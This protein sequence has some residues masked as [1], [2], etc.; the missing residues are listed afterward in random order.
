MVLLYLTCWTSSTVLPLLIKICS[1]SSTSSNSTSKMIWIIVSSL[2]FGN[3]FSI[4]THNTARPWRQC[5]Q[6]SGDFVLYAKTRLEKIWKLFEIDLTV[7]LEYARS[8]KIV[9]RIDDLG[10]LWFFSRKHSFPNK[11][12]NTWPQL[13]SIITY[14]T[15]AAA[16][17][18]I[19]FATVR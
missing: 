7:Q 15:P 4:K 19:N 1:K 18:H 10:W 9:K 11:A 5:R 2:M 16:N 13:V 8:D 6:T 3:F 14:M 12:F 17:K